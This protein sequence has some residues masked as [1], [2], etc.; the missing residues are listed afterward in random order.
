MNSLTEHNNTYFDGIETIL[1][2]DNRL[3]D[4][5]LSIRTKVCCMRLM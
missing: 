1:Y 2:D 5:F 4:I 3:N